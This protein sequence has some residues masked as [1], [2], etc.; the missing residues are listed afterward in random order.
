MGRVILFTVTITRAPAVL[1][2]MNMLFIMLCLMKIR[3][4]PLRRGPGK[5]QEEE[6]EDFPQFRPRQKKYPSGITL[7]QSIFLSNIMRLPYHSFSTLSILFS[8]KKFQ[9]SLPCTEKGFKNYFKKNSAAFK[10]GQPG[11]VIHACQNVLFRVTCE[12]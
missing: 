4:F 5:E 3:L 10:S 8:V 6:Q 2:R 11:K 7:L 12:S 1:P 9:R